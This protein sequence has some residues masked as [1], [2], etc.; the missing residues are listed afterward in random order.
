MFSQLITWFLSAPVLG[1]MVLV[2]LALVSAIA[3]V[4]VSHTNR[5]MFGE[6]QKLQ[7]EQDSLDSKYGKLLLEQ[8]AWTEY[9][10]VE[11]LSINKLA[12]LPVN[13][14]VTVVIRQGIVQ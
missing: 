3:V 13:P 1:G 5:Q 10:R 6:L 2:L 9:S 12:M 4:A 8:S 11:E 7:Y 14:D